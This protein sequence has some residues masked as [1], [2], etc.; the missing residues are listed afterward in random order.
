MA[1]EYTGPEQIVFMTGNEGKLREAREILGQDRIVSSKEY[2]GSKIDLP[3]IQSMDPKEI[4][5]AKL[6]EA[7]AA[8]DL[9]VDQVMNTTDFQGEVDPVMI[10]VEDTSLRGEGKLKG[11]PGPL[12]KH[13]AD[14]LGL[15]AM[16]D[17]CQ[18]IVGEDEEIGCTAITILGV[19][20]PDGDIEYFT[21]EVAGFMYEPSGDMGFGWDPI[22]EPS[23]QPDDNPRTFAEMTPEEKNAISMRRR[24]LEKLKKHLGW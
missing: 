15:E 13:V 16:V 5:W 12:V 21:G 24:A 6:E 11:F 23:E 3:E 17:A 20:F 2:F 4:I 18:A 1:E 22:F 7:R 10:M 19:S 9:R 14:T 8:F